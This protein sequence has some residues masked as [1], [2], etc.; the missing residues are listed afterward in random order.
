MHSHTSTYRAII[1]EGS[2]LHWIEGED[3]G[4]VEPVGKGG[5]WLQPGDQVHGDENVSEEPSLSLIV[6]DGPLDFIMAE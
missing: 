1:I 3:K 2:A 5:Y 4:S 6:F